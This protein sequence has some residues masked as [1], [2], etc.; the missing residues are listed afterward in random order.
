MRNLYGAPSFPNM[1]ETTVSGL[2]RPA[3]ECP[4]VRPFLG[5]IAQTVRT[6]RLDIPI[7]VDRDDP[8]RATC[9]LL[10]FDDWGWLCGF[11]ERP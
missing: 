3:D 7:S 4:L 10:I 8:V 9:V 6:A 1:V 5:G 2:C 11:Q